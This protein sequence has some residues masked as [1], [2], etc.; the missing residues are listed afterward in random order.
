MVHGDL[1]AAHVLLDERGRPRLCGFGQATDHTDD[2]AADD[3]AAIGRLLARLFKAGGDLPWAR[4][5]AAGAAARQRQARKDLD[6]IVAQATRERRDQRLTARQLSKAVHAAVPECSLPEP[7]PAPDRPARGS[8]SCRATSTRP[9]DLSW[10]DA[11]LT[12]LAAAADDGR[13]ADELADTGPYAGLG[14]LDE[15]DDDGTDEDWA[16]LAAAPESVTVPLPVF[17]P[18]DDGPRERPGSSTTSPRRPSPGRACAAAP[19][20]HRGTPPAPPARPR[21]PAARGAGHRRRRRRRRRPGR[22]PLGV[23]PVSAADPEPTTTDDGASTPA[24]PRHGA[25]RTAD[26]RA[27]PDRGLAG[28]LRRPEPT[29]PDVDGDGCPAHRLPRPHRPCRT[30]TS[31]G[32]DGDVVALGDWAA[33]GR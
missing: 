16:A 7:V 11:D 9:L 4:P 1:E 12:W 17:T 33:P 30:V 29:G 32:Q 31:V 28:A 10:T 6:G 5:P 3:V 27:G 20:R 24:A 21:R 18:P 13:A 26:D 19:G 15:L 25:G 8:P 23:R 14:S 2:G 22:R